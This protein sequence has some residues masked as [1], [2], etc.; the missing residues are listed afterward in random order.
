[1]RK[2][3][4]RLLGTNLPAAGGAYLRF[5]PLALIRSALKQSERAGF[6]GTFYIHPWEL[7]A[8]VPDLRISRV[9]RIRTFS[10]LGD[11]WLRIGALLR[12]F[13]FERVDRLLDRVTPA[14]VTLP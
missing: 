11:T 8:F 10:S 9:A 4:L 6:P 2:A 12:E 13:R 3:T 14:T 7:D 1:M 5:F